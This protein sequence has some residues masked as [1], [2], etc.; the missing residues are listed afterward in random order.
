MK[1]IQKISFLSEKN[2][3]DHFYSEEAKKLF[4]CVVRE[5][6]IDK[7]SDSKLFKSINQDFFIILQRMKMKVNIAD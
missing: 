5:K 6:P 3:E 1:F 4:A 7:Q 2:K